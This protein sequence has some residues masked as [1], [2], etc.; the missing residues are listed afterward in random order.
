M[1]PI[2]ARTVNVALHQVRASG[3]SIT[4]K[5]FGDQWTHPTDIMSVLLLL[6]GEIVN[7]ALARLAGGRITPVAF[8][9]G[10]S[11]LC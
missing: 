7:R 8:S 10:A 3:S 6:G 1:A 11:L 2:E 4:A 9:F 5:E